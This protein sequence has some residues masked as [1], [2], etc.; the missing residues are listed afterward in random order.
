MILELL[1]GVAQ[2]GIVGQALVE[3]GEALL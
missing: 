2:V 3:E 1:P